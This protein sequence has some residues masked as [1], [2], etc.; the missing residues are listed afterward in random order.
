MKVKDMMAGFALYQP[1]NLRDALALLDTVGPGTWKLAG[2]NDSLVWFKEQ[3]K[4]PKAVVDLAG[5][6]ELRGI[7]ATPGGIEIG[8]CAQRA[9]KFQA[10]LAGGRQLPGQ[11]I[12]PIGESDDLGDFAHDLSRRSERQVLA[13]ETGSHGAVL[14]HRHAHERLHDLV[15]A[16]KAAASDAIGG[17]AGDVPAFE[18]DPPLIGRIDTVDEIE[19]GRL[20]RTVGA[21]ET[22][23]LAVSHRET[24]IMHRL[25]APKALADPGDF[26]ERCHGSSLR[27]RG[28]RP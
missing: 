23:D 21:N 9:S 19:H 16:G 11:V 17:L 22:K 5:L 12:Q 18:R 3:I 20:A 10:F 14:K 6:E 8:A 1:G 13:P 26:E 27:T 7:R 25:Q 28:Q 15:G 2:G 24:Q 4:Q